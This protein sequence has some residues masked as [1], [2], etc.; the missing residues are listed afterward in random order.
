MC[1]IDRMKRPLSYRKQSTILQFN[2]NV[3]IQF[4]NKYRDENSTSSLC[5]DG[6]LNKNEFNYTLKTTL[7]KEGWI[8][9][10][11]KKRCQ[12][13][14]YDQKDVVQCLNSALISLPLDG[15]R[16]LS[17]AFIGNSRIR[18]QFYSFMEVSE[19]NIH[20]KLLF[21]IIYYQ[22]CFHR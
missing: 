7:E 14:H 5:L 20:R 18:H 10:R 13:L 8:M 19:K 17:F 9:M 21:A 12:L 11:P 15:D 3:I 2:K 22:Y 4:E 16:K 6:L 1:A